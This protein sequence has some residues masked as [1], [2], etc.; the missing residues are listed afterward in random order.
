M[1]ATLTAAIDR[2]DLL[3]LV[4]RLSLLLAVLNTNEDRPLFVLAV[5]ACAVAFPSPRIHLSPWLWLGLGLVIGVRQL[6]AWEGVDNHVIVTTYWLFALGLS[7]LAPDPLAALRTN[8]RV[9]IGLVFAFAVFWKLFSPSFVDGRFFRYTLLLDD[10]FSWLATGVGG[11]PEAAYDANYGRV[12]SLRAAEAGGA[13][14]LVE[15]GRIRTLAAVMTGWGLA[16]E[17][18]V[19]ASMLAPLPGRWR[20]LRHA[21]VLAFCL[22]TYLV[23]PIGGFGCLLAVLG[24]ALAGDD[25]LP[26]R[27]YVLLFATLVLYTPLWR[28]LF[29]P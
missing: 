15:T 29:G 12:Q 5:V 28:V 7:L 9:L 26:R 22:T 4:A 19:A 16:V 18:L 23:V 24:L 21:G 13:V 6:W 14:T 10:R 27:T 3:S 1:T 2:A 8:G 25:V 20:W 17:A 11:M